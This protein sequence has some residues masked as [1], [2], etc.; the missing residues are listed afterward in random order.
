MSTTAF[1][2]SLSL[3]LSYILIYVFI[4]SFDYKSI[5]KYLLIIIF[6]ILLRNYYLQD[7]YTY[8]S[9]DHTNTS[10]NTIISKA[11]VPGRYKYMI[12]GDIDN[13]KD[14][15]YKM[16]Y[17]FI[18]D[19][20]IF[21]SEYN[22]RSIAFK[23]YVY[24]YFGVNVEYVDIDTYNELKDLEFNDIINYKDDIIIINFDEVNYEE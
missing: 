3:V 13:S 22:L 8:L 10:Y 6:T 9:L 20:S 21:W 5:Y 11:I 1:R 14:N 7:Q 12:I 23:K 15:I 17:G 4:L 2:Y 16:N 24:Y 18:S 19:E